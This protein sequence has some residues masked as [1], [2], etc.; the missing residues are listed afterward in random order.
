MAG[1]S[2]DFREHKQ[3]T[4]HK[5]ERTT[6]SEVQLEFALKEVVQRYALANWHSDE[7]I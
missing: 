6:N 5:S 4:F 7:I 2:S 3:H 1:H